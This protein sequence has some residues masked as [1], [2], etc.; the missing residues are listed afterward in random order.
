MRVVVIGSGLIGVTAAFVL[1]RRGH[2]VTVVDRA[3]GPGRETSF[4]NG[5]L[6]TPS[7]SQPWSTPGCWRVLLSSL[8]RKEAP[9]QV[10]LRTLPSMAGWGVR[11]LR[12]STQVAFDKNTLSN[13]RLGLYSLGITQRLQRET[14]IHYGQTA[15][16]AL[17]LFRDPV[18]LAFAAR[19]ASRLATEGLSFRTL[20]AT[21]AVELEPALAPIAQELSGAIY[22][23]IDETG[24][25]HRFCVALAERAR[26]DGAQFLFGTEISSLEV[27]ADHITGVVGAQKRFVADRYVVAAGSFTTGL[28]KPLGIPLPVQ[29]VKGYS[30]TFKDPAEASLRIPVIDDS[31][32][33]AIVPLEGAIR[34]AG[35]AEFAGFDR[36]LGPARVRNLQRLLRGVLPR[37]PFEDSSSKP[38]CGLRPVCVDGVPIIGP[39][40]L[41]NLFVSS[42]HGH[43]GWTLA[44]GSAQLLVDLL[45]GVRPEIDPA[46]YVLSRFASCRRCWD[47]GP[48]GPTSP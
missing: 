37:V 46:P 25:A 17:K 19:A 5:S 2:E 36:T 44:A 33:A 35:T 16:G 1:R 43:L 38:W 6:L 27:E 34:V 4:A 23:P 10:R 15:R 31:L 8:F 32:H 13:L 9:L 14:G 40:P 21:E 12:N 28:L 45:E 48:T 18:P 30:V 41:A 24:D 22:Y 26:R 47:V 42:G 20:S 29:P 7:M 3:E 11:F 39:T